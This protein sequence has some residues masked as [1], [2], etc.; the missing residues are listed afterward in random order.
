MGREKLGYREIWLWNEFS[1]SVL[2]LFEMKMKLVYSLQS[3]CF[4]LFFICLFCFLGFSFVFLGFVLFCLFLLVCFFV[5]KSILQGSQT[6]E[7][8]GIVI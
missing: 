6:Q 1:F 8:P 2:L 5:G 3:Y 7:R 4:V